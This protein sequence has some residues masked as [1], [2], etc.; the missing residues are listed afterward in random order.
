MAEKTGIAWCDSTFS[1]WEGCS[2]ISLACD[3][4]FAKARNARFGGGTAPNWGPGAPRRR[5]SASTWKQPLRWNKHPFVECASCG[6]RGEL[7]KFSV[8]DSHG[9]EHTM[10]P[11]C[12]GG[13]YISTRRR[14]FC[15]SLCDVFDNEVEC[16]WRNDLYS[17]ILETPNLD[18]LLLT[19]RIG[20]YQKVFDY[21]PAL[22]RNVW[23]GIT[24]CNQEEAD[25]DIP[26]LLKVPAAKH[27]LSIEPMLGP[28]DLRLMT[29]A[30]LWAGDGAYAPAARTERL[31][32]HWVICGSESG[33]GARRDPNMLTWV[34]SLRDQCVAAR[35]P[36]FWKQDA[37]NGKK[38]PTPELD[39][40]TWTEVP[41]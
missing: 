40:R 11:H 18:W 24:V 33:P 19:K 16:E 17:L 29:C 21:A 38:I 6:W 36:F 37:I 27:F 1:P 35:I 9:F 2:Q 13:D 30:P 23:L 4:C 28:I 31:G 15:G 20:N 22:P 25:R 41:A 10:C 8:D 39:G 3:N 34:R 5:M 12:N 26:K 7:R 14:V 32:L